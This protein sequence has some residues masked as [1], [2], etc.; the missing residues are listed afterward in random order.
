MTKVDASQEEELAPRRSQQD[1]TATGRLA[2][3]RIRRCAVR[4][5]GVLV[6][7]LMAAV[8]FQLVGSGASDLPQPA[9]PFTFR[10]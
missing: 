2:V 6:V 3:R 9:S 10:V 4:V 1:T 5:I 8:V 7:A